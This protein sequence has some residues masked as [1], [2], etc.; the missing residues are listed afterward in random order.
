MKSL[1]DEQ[2]FCKLWYRA[3]HVDQLGVFQTDVGSDPSVSMQ[4]T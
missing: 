2:H 1:F 4:Y 3:Q